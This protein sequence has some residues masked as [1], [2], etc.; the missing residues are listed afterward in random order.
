MPSVKV[1]N[2]EIFSLLDQAF[3][4]PYSAAFPAVPAEGWER[5]RSVYP[6]C[7]DAQGNWATNAQ[8]FLI[9]SA[10]QNVLVD[11]GLGPGSG[12][13]GQGGNL[14]AA[15]RDAGVGPADVNIVIFTHL[16]YDHTGWAVVD[17]KPL[18]S[19]ARY[20]V[21][22]ADWKQLGNSAALFAEEAALKPAQD[23]GKVELVSG[24]KSV[25]PEITLLP[26]PGHTPGHQSV[27][28]VSAG[29]RAI[30]LGDVFNHPAQ[31]NE[32]LWNA[33]FDFDQSQAPETR[34]R[35]MERLE[36]DGS[37]VASG[38]YPAPGF[39]RLVRED[40]RRI[41]RTL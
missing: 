21:P 33:G 8:P 13:G 20:L 30:V 9:R 1:G 35:V 5:Y 7:W 27:I 29:Q 10:G 18:F 24:E 31:A 17:G 34:R 40:G 19:N 2:A 25:T 38:H 11:T 32:L 23:A 37:I 14:Q 16:H 6:A 15:L 22:E 12:D 36:Q 4:F 39:G 28:I 3:A 41:Y 26:T